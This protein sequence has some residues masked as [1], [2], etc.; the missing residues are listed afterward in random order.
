[1]ACSCNTNRA[2][3]MCQ[4]CNME[5]CLDCIEPETGLCWICEYLETSKMFDSETGD[6][7]DSDD[8]KNKKSD[9]D[10]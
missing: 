10:K 2:F 3:T 5:G 4:C 9:S 8:L 1:M 7:D 6:S